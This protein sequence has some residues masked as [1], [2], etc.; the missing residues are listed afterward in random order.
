M[1]VSSTEYCNNKDTD[2]DSIKSEKKP[3]GART[4][5]SESGT[6]I[7]KLPSSFVFHSD[8]KRVDVFYIHCRRER[9]FSYT[10][11]LELI[12]NDLVWIGNNL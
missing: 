7:N 9:S 11:Y 10:H 1:K 5:R 4:T 2:N 3:K 8:S 12:G 6:K